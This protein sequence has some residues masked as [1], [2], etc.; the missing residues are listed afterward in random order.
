[1]NNCTNGNRSASSTK[2]HAGRDHNQEVQRLLAAAQR[3]IRN[4]L[5]ITVCDGKVPIG[6]RRWH[7]RRITEADLPRL[8]RSATSPAIGIQLG[9]DSAIDIECDSDAEEKIF[10][11]LFAECVQPKTPTYKSP[12]G[13]HRLFRFHDRFRGTNRAV[14]NFPGM[15]ANRSKLGVRIGADGKGAQSIVPPSTKRK[16][17]KGLS[18]HDV[19]LATLPELVVDRILGALKAKEP[20]QASSLS[21]WPVSFARQAALVAMLRIAEKSAENDS[22]RRLYAV[23]CCAVAHGLN[24]VEAIATI[25][26]YEERHPFQ[27][28]W[29]DAEIRT[30]LRDA[31][32]EVKRGSAAL[33][34][35]AERN[36]KLSG[37]AKAAPL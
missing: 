21:T 27:R 14:I 29:S 1:M 26:R 32:R 16:W 15:A 2:S 36:S 13:K 22:S 3:Y 8:L 34:H 5:T 4:G 24:D 19:A 23:S 7:T 31:E 11:E 12:R 10:V 18:I 30:R 6:G 28:Q 37:G 17:Y 20:V 9:P 33:G 25:R 35:V